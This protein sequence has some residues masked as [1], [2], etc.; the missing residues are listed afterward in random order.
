[1]MREKAWIFGITPLVGSSTAGRLN[2]QDCGAD[3]AE[4]AVACVDALSD[5]PMRAGGDS[6]MDVGGVALPWVFAL[7]FMVGFLQAVGVDCWRALRRWC[8]GRFARKDDK[9]SP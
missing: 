4:R 5:L 8:A 2:G 7:M 6:A 1:M 9:S 3:A